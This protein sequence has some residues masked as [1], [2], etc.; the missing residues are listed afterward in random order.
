MKRFV[1]T[2]SSTAATMPKPGKKFT[3]YKDTWNDESVR[4]AKQDKPDAFTVYAASKTEG[5]KH[6]W[7]WVEENKPSFVVNA[8]TYHSHRGIQHRH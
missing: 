7:N 4:L 3:V 1:F 8:G 6:V 2:S 5:E